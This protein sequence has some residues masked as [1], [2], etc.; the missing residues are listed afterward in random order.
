MRG[1][2]AEE[3]L[4][5]SRHEVP[6]L[7][8]PDD[9]D[10]L[11]ELQQLPHTVDRVVGHRDPRDVRSR[12]RAAPAQAAPRMRR[13]RSR[14]FV[15][16][17][18]VTTTSSRRSS[19]SPSSR[20]RAGRSGRG[21]GVEAGRAL[22]THSGGSARTVVVVPDRRPRDTNG[23][24]GEHTVGI[25][26]DLT[27]VAVPARAVRDGELPAAP[28]VTSERR[29]VGPRSRW[30]TIPVVD[31]DHLRQRQQFGSRVRW[32]R[33]PGA[34][35]ELVDGVPRGGVDTELPGPAHVDPQ[36]AAGRPPRTR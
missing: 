6:C 23:R 21:T 26:D 4:G 5:Q 16:R 13:A 28:Q 14:R 34:C 35:G 30:R 10:V 9:L 8:R 19:A 20:A 27:F 2:T 12:P 15:A 18:A 1:M 11:A 17:S 29:D 22:S 7:G 25:D 32:G 31:G 33:A 3:R 36:G 24:A